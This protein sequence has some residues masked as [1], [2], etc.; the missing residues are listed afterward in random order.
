[1]DYLVGFIL[2]Y[3]LKEIGLLIKRVS[4]WDLSNRSVYDK[5]WDFFSVHEDDPP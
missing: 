5:D 3:F 2:G 4:E 1:M